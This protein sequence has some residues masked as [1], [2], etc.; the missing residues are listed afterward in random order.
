MRVF[1]SIDPVYT[2]TIAI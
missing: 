2:S 1:D